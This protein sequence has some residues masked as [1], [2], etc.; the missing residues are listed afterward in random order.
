M[1]LSS[2]L[3]MHIYILC[4]YSA[5]FLFWE[6]TCG[7]LLAS[8]S[9]CYIWLLEQARGRSSLL[10][11]ENQSED[12]IVALGSPHLYLRTCPSHSGI[13]RAYLSNDQT[14]VLTTHANIYNFIKFI[15]EGWVYSGCVKEQKFSNSHHLPEIKSGFCKA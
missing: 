5:H 14:P 4:T 12:P 10:Q 2:I 9:I 1:L 15:R 8:S 13:S 6:A 3:L 7:K 11:S